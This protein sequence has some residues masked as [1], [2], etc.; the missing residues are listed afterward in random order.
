[1]QRHAGIERA[2]AAKPGTTNPSNS[3]NRLAGLLKDS[4]A[5]IGGMLGMSGGGPQGAAAGYAAGKAAGGVA[6][7][8]NAAEARRLF[9]GDMPVAPLGARIGAAIGGGSKRLAPPAA[10]DLLERQRRE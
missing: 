6:D 5:T 4:L 8:R 1:M 3:G 2:I 10:V 9:R 7:F